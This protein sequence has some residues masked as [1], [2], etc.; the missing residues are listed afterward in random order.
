MKIL[1]VVPCVRTAVP[2]FPRIYPMP[3]GLASI[4]AYIRANSNNE[5]EIKDF[6]VPYQQKI[7]SPPKSF[8]GLGRMNFLHYGASYEE[9][10]H[11][12]QDHAGDY[13]IIGISSLQISLVEDGCCKVADIFKEHTKAPIVV[14]GYSATTNPELIFSHCKADW[15]IRGEGERPFLNFLREYESEMLPPS[16]GVYNVKFDQIKNLDEL[17]DPA[18]D[19]CALKDYPTYHK[20]QRIVI[21]TSRGC[22]FDCTFCSVKLLT[23]QENIHGGL[24]PCWRRHSPEYVIKQVES[25]YSRYSARFFCILDDNFLA[26]L[27]RAKIILDGIEALNL[28]GIF[29]YIEEGIMVRQAAEH[30]ELIEQLVRM[31]FENLV[32]GLESMSERTQQYIKKPETKTEFKTALETF[33]KLNYRPNVFYIL[34]FKSDTVR[35]MLESMMEL[36]EFKISIRVNNLQILPKTD[37]YY[38]YIEEDLLNIEKWDWRISS[39]YT[40]PASD[41]SFQDILNLKRLL[42]GVNYGCEHDVDVFRAS[43]EEFSEKIPFTLLQPKAGFPITS[44]LKSLYGKNISRFKTFLRLLAV[45]LDFSGVSFNVDKD[46]RT[47]RLVESGRERGK[48]N[49]VER[50]LKALLKEKGLMLAHKPDLTRWFGVE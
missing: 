35:S 44:E 20:V 7:L 32:L 12:A 40:P 48:L 2:Y 10:D 21:S 11:W 46:N 33:K 27:K 25:F 13:D 1:L 14:G 49:K 29:F 22:P 3:I 47:I 8:R 23:G 38:E 45:R 39:F 15:I 37:L 5:V 31:K 26:D 18:W 16:S 42:N 17:P 30:P 41:F 24:I 36:A 43:L 34:G 6:L 4:A 28:K 9:V 50:E 19:L